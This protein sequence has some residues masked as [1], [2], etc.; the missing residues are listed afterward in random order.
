MTQAQELPTT[1]A[2]GFAFPIGTK[3]TVKL[4][5]IDSIHFNYSVIAFATENEVS[6]GYF[7]VGQAIIYT[8]DKGLIQWKANNSV[9]VKI[10]VVAFIK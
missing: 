7:G 2:K 8:D 4:I 6:L 10:D 9:S 1:P 5:P 3:F